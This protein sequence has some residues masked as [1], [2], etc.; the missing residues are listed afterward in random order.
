MA[1][2]TCVP[3]SDYR[4]CIEGVRGVLAELSACRHDFEQ[5]VTDMS[6]Q[7][8]EL[9]QQCEML[10][11]DRAELRSGLEAAGRQTAEL[12]EQLAG[13]KRQ[14][15]RREASWGGEL[16]Q[17]RRLLESLNRRLPQE[18]DENRAKVGNRR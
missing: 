3:V 15:A 13:E 14:N 12:A 18:N 10:E 6:D 4:E 16:K 1:T 2:E 9:R 7:C 11:R 8:D 5:F 17:L